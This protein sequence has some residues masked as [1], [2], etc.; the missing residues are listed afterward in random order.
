M[1]KSYLF[2]LVAFLFAACTPSE[3]NTPKELT[4]IE[5]NKKSVEI[6]VGQDFQLRVWYEP[7]E[8]E[9]FAPEVVWES[10]KTKVATVD[11]NGKV[12]GKS[13]GKTVITAT[14]GKF[15]AECDVE[16][17]PEPEPVAVESISLDKTDLSMFIG[18]ECLLRVIYSPEESERHAAEIVWSSSAPS[19][20]TV[21]SEGLVTA[22][23]E[24]SAIIT[25][26]CGTLK[27]TC[28]VSIMSNGISVSPKYV[29]SKEAGGTYNVRISSSS[30][31]SA[32]YDSDWFTVSPQSGASSQDVTIVIG[33]SSS[34]SSRFGSVVFSNEVE[35]D[36][37]Y[38]SQEGKVFLFSV[39]SG[40]TAIF[41]QGNLQY[42]ASTNTWRF[43]ENQYDAIGSDNENRTDTYSGWIDLFTWG[44]GDCPT[45]TSQ[46]NYEMKAAEYADYTKIITFYEFG[47]N[48]IANGGNYKW[49]TPTKD[50]WIY[51]YT[52]RS[53]AENLRGN[54]TVNEMK[55]Y[56]LLPDNFENTSS[57][58]FTPM[59]GDF[60]V[61]A[62]SASEWLQLQ[63]CGA[64]FLPSSGYLDWASGYLD[65]RK[66]NSE[67]GPTYW[68]STEKESTQGKKVGSSIYSVKY[69]AYAFDP[70]NSYVTG[71]DPTY[72]Q[73]KYI[74]FPVRLIR[75]YQ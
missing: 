34:S 19:V 31:W 52:T 69:G 13:V 33:S 7:E 11:D 65:V 28:S 72:W 71:N 67:D 48:K 50:E 53:N 18:D 20:V 75:E 74:G 57:V 55:G 5:L 2:L 43:A 23:A 64:I 37:L 63:A 26:A 10:S 35:S 61:N 22:V 60:T 68:S 6:E 3:N 58:A 12:H 44:G 30:S 41:A 70:N 1:K 25:A 40:K 8:A 29:T 46:G 54:A 36:T 62:Y 16:V 59:A 38:V 51:L 47:N 39:S 42:Q 27:A 9:D 14:C 4:G 17:V 49:R 45:L 56:I 66:Y 24:G 15:T 21:S 32:D 73:N